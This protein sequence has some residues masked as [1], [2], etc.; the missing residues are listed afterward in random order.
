MTTTR[1]TRPAHSR[2]PVPAEALERRVLLAGQ[3]YVGDG[4]AG[5]IGTYDQ[6][7][8][9]AVNASLISGLSYGSG[10]YGSV[11]VSGQDVFVLNSFAGTVGEYTTSGATVNASLITGLTSQIPFGM[12]VVGS[13]LYVVYGNGGSS[14]TNGHVDRYTLGATPGT[15]DAAATVT[16]LISGIADADAVLVSGSTIYVSDYAL[17]TIG[18]YSLAG[19]P[20]NPSLV[21]G[22]SNPEDMTLVGSTLFVTEQGGGQCVGAYSLSGATVNAALIPNLAGPYKIAGANGDLFV[23]VG[24][25]IEEYATDGTPVNTSLI[26]GV[27]SVF[28]IAVAA[29]VTTTAAQLSLVAQP[30]AGTATVPL[31]GVQVEVDDATGVLESTD[32]STV[33]LAIATGPAGATLSGTTTVTSNGGVA[34]FGNISVSLPGTYTFT[35]TDGSLTAVTT[36]P[37][38]VVTPVIKT[39]GAPDPT[40]GT[41]GLASHAVG[42]TS[43]TGVAA[44]GAQSVLV[45]PIGAVPSESFGVTRNNADGSLDTTFGAGGVVSTPFAGTDAVPAAVAV[46]A[47]G[48]ILVAGTATTYAADGV[49]V[50]GSQFAVAEYTAAGALD[51]SFGT[52]GQVLFGTGASSLSHDVLRALAVGPGGVIYLGGRS[53]V[54][55]TNDLAVV[56]LSATGSANPAYGTTR[57]VL[58]G[59]AGGSDQINGLAVQKNGDLVAAGS[60]VVG[61]TTEVVVARYLPTG[62]LD[63]R[64]GTKGFTTDAVGNVY[65][66]AS[67]VVITGKGQIVIGGLTASGSGATLSSDF[68]VQRYTANGKLDRSFGTGGSTVTSFGQPAAVTQ[69]ALQTDGS[70]VASGRTSAALGGTQSLAVARYTLRG[71]ADETFNHTGTV[72][73]DLAGATATPA[74]LLAAVAGDLGAAFDAFT[75]SS[76]GVVAVSAGGEILTAGNS[77]A[78]T[79]EAE[80]VTAG[81]DL[82]AKLLSTLP[83]AVLAGAKGTATV[84]VTEGGTTLASGSVTLT[85]SFATDAAGTDAAVAKSMATKV[86]LKAGQSRTYKLA[87]AYPAAAT[88]GGYY[89]LATVI[90]GTGLP[91][92]LDGYNNVAASPADVAVAPAFVSLAGSGLSTT[93]ITAGRPAT[94]SLVLVNN[95]NVAARG[96]ITVDFYLSTGD[97]TSGATQV[98]STKVA[99]GL[100]AGRPHPYRLKF[101]APATLA[102]GTFNLLAVVDPALTLSAGDRTVAT[103]VDATPV[104]VG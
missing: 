40:F 5:T 84:T 85:V 34:V 100:S 17:G 49:T 4:G 58:T 23:G 3:I 30:T 77:G 57:M 26:T 19:D 28:G 2:Y 27:D 43:T 25:A 35:A 47:D 68:L 37:F 31:A 74:A 83:A 18:S 98:G 53:D 91:P 70:L 7:T 55:G 50:I 9:A 41:G 69:V 52:G 44:D 42:F 38:T 65:D 64:F 93:T 63:P 102:A 82:V 8:G 1:R 48:D 54:A 29:D 94:A 71:L 75:S 104:T 45:G 81:V 78:N 103:V 88:A 14:A 99:I 79:V 76:L 86:S 80:L 6:T 73:V 20:I 62:V 36:A 95:G 15:I 32:G 97:T 46:L 59:V 12:T 61:G 96:S 22:L 33:T 87:F 11:A 21:T 39:V 90:D 16:N 66:S 56:S 92:D 51:P 101:T 67:S 60:A 13:N 24:S 89:L 10:P 72:V